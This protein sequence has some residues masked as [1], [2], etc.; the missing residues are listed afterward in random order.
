M[1]GLAAKLLQVNSLFISLSIRGS[2]RRKKR[3]FLGWGQPSV[4]AGNSS[5][6]SPFSFPFIWDQPICVYKKCSMKQLPWASYRGFK[7][8][9][10]CKANC[11][12]GG[13]MAI[14]KF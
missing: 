9:W 13:Q 5:L 3:L 4:M 14:Y 1:K 10:Y 12:Q 11:N 7:N 2:L 6:S 8:C